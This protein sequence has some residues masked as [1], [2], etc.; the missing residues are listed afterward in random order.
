MKNQRDANE[1]EIVR[2]LIGV[3]ATVRRLDASIGGEMAGLPDLLVGYRGMNYLLEVKRFKGSLNGISI[4]ASL[5][6]SQRKFWN[7]W[8]GSAT[9]VRNATE[10]LRA[11]G[12]ITGSQSVEL[13]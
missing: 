10:A 4:V 5:S 13:Q 3:G 12:A 1:E 6:P 11:I 2:A 7:S 9:I 8:N